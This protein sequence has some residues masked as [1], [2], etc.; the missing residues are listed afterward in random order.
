MPDKLPCR[1]Q[2]LSFPYHPPFPSLPLP[3]LFSSSFAPAQ[4]P[5][6]L[7]SAC[8][9]A[10]TTKKRLYLD[11]FTPCL[12]GCRNANEVAQRRVRFS[13]PTVTYFQRCSLTHHYLAYSTIQIKI[14][15]AYH[16]SS[17]RVLR[18]TRH[19]F[20]LGHPTA[21]CTSA[22]P[23]VPRSASRSPQPPWTTAGLLFKNQRA[24]TRAGLP[25]LIC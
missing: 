20:N 1:P 9:Y 5:C 18:A 7:P 12:A 10:C 15:R 16:P 24:A 3:C 2:S 17:D 23:S 21:S 11:E 6:T 13:R 4:I 8:T 22:R 25:R 19:S 14:E